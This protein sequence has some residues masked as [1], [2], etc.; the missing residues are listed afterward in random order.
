MANSGACVDVHTIS[1]VL[2][3]TE[4]VARLPGGQSH[5]PFLLVVGPAMASSNDI[6]GVPLLEGSEAV[7]G[8]LPVDAG[9]VTVSVDPGA[10]EAKADNAAGSTSA[11]PRSASD[12]SASSGGRFG[13]GSLQHPGTGRRVDP[14]PVWCLVGV[15]VLAVWRAH[16]HTCVLGRISSFRVASPTPNRTQWTTKLTMRRC[17]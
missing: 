2:A 16:C 11:R 10:A 13:A 17:G 8:T 14:E 3:H 15:H 5:R 6:G 9:S 7:V 1:P 12:S 4:G